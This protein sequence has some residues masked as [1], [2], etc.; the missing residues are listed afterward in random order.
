[1]PAAPDRYQSKT[2][3]DV[4]NRKKEGGSKEKQI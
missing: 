2:K 3:N 4:F 1:V